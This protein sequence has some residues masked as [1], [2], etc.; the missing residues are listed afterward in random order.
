MAKI[1]AVPGIAKAVG[2][3]YNKTAVATPP[4]TTA[5]LLSMVK[6]GK[7]FGLNIS[8]YFMFGFWSGFGGTFNGQHR[9]MRC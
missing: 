4:A 8:D 6:A 7:K 1:Y 3:Y 5:D 9:Q 2:L